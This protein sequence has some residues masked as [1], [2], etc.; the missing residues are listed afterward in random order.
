MQRAFPILLLAVAASGCVGSDFDFEATASDARILPRFSYAYDGEGVARAEGELSIAADSDKDTGR[1][2]MTVRQTSTTYTLDWDAF[3]G[4][5][6]FQSGGVVR[7]ITL[8]GTTG[9]GSADLPAFFA[10]LGLWGQTD[11][12]VNG[13][14]ENDPIRGAPGFDARLYVVRGRV[15][16]AETGIIHDGQ[17]TGPYDPADP[18]DAFVD[19]EGSQAVVELRT[20]TGD[21]WAHFEF[22][23]VRITRI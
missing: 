16:D 21:L 14:A 7:G 12:Y 11:L 18:E 13:R 23:N 6:P 15:R 19:A 3:D 4:A 9:N 17:K 2:T 5:E 8:H 10:Y 22:E 20:A 1:V